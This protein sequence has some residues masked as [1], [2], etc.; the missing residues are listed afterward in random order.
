MKNVLVVGL[1][2]FGLGI[3]KKLR[4]MGY[5]VLAVDRQEERAHAALPYVTD[6]QIGDSTSPEFLDTLEVPGFDCCFVAI[7]DDFQSV[8]ETTALL[9]EKGAKFIISRAARDIQK[10]LL[11]SIGADRVVYPEGQLAEWAAV[12]YTSEQILNYTALGIDCALYEVRIPADWM[13]KTIGEL[14]IPGRHR[15]RLIGVKKEGEVHAELSPDSVLSQGM[16]LLL[17]GRNEDIH[18]LFG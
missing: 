6:I 7:S 11:L 4:E 14:D 10:K 15:L 1:G 5:D 16:T 12:C 17:M 18:K 2:R 3:A 8:M 13:E 9:R